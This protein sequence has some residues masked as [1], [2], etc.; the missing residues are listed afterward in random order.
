VTLTALS[1]QSIINYG[2]K[3][4]LIERTPH[5][6]GDLIRI[7]QGQAPL[8][9]YFRNNILHV[10]IIASLCASLIER[11]GN[12][13]LDNI[14]RI[15]GIMYP[16]L[17]AELFLKYPGRTLDETL[18]EHINTLIEEHIIVEKDPDLAH[19]PERVRVLSTPEPNTRSYQQLSVLANSVEQSLERYFM[20]LALL[21]QQGS[22]KLSKE[23]VIDLGYLLGQRLSVIYEDDMPDFF[24]RALFSSFLDALER[25]GYIRLSATGLIEFDQRIDNM[26]KS[27]RF[28]LDLD[29][30]HI[31]QQISQLTSEEIE[32]TLKELQD[33][34][35]RKFSRKK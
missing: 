34:K 22:G 20:I 11:N 19:Q 35:Q 7:A 16:F 24:D 23:Q 29:V 21:S 1:P 9:S 8:L 32:R 6:L 17:Q 28:I 10:Y 14:K 18:T 30:M 12:I 2:I 15:V 3:L 26:A 13:T 31:L 25:L 27:A 4:K 33:K 5:V